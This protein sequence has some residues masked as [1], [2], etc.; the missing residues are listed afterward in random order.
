MK[1][2]IVWLLKNE[3]AARQIYEKAAVIFQDD[4]DLK[5]LLETLAEDEVFHV[6]IMEEASEFLQRKTGPL[7]EAILLDDQTR[8][9]IDRQIEHVR[10]LIDTGNLSK[11]SLLEYIIC[12]ERS[13]WNPLFLYV[14]NTLKQHCPEFSTVGPKLQQHLRSIER[15]IETTGEQIDTLD[16]LRALTPVW[17]EG[18]LIVDDS[19]AITELLAEL[20][21]RAGDIDTAADGAEALEKAIRR[22]YAVIVSDID[23]PV[24]NGLDFFRNL[25]SFYASAADRFVFMTGFPTP[26]IIEF[27]RIKGIPLLRK[28]FGLN[29]LN[30]RV[31]RILESNV[32]RK[33]L[34]ELACR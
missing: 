18:I 4:E 26:D 14:V 17:E 16:D 34:R 13:E 5:E 27:C 24:M 19:P 2:I 25:E 20:L 33:P 32:R 31:Y 21:A 28:P 10:S 7:E 6:R 23:M 12:A 29:E 3:E 22:Y 8:N 30:D 15:Y 9:R 11:K 1:D